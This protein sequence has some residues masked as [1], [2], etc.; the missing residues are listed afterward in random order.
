[1]APIRDANGRTTHFV[2]IS[3]DLSELQD[4]PGLWSGRR[5]PLNPPP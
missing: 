2:S 5:S 4:A 1:V 3:Q